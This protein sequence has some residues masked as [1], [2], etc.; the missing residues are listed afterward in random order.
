MKR[1]TALVLVLATGSASCAT[2]F[3]GSPHVENG[4][5]GCEAKCRGQGMELAG[6]VYLGEYSSGCV[7]EVPARA[8]AG[9]RR[10]LL[11]SAGG[12]AAGAVGVELQRRAQEQNQQ[13]QM[14]HY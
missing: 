7:C 11:A 13:M 3:T 6:M 14:H 2:N 10:V 12:A 4:R 8:G 1:V 5:A 9:P